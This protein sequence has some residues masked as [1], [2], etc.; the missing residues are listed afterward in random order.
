MAVATA[1][2]GLHV[3]AGNAGA[4]W[5]LQVLAG[6]AAEQPRR[7][8]QPPLDSRSLYRML[9]EG[10]LASAASVAED[11]FEELLTEEIA[12]Y[13][14]S[15][16]VGAGI[17][18]DSPYTLRLLLRAF[19]LRDGLPAPVASELKQLSGAAL[20]VSD[21]AL[22]RAGLGRNS[23]PEG[24]PGRL[25]VPPAREL[26][27]LQR[28]MAFQVDDLAPLLPRSQ[29]GVLDPLTIGVASCRFSDSQLRGGA[30]DR[31][32][33]LRGGDWM[34]LAR[35]FS[36]CTAVRHRVVHQVVA[37]LGPDAATVLFGAE[38]DADVAEAF[39][40]MK[41]P[42][43]IV[44]RRDE[45]EPFSLLRARCDIDKVIAAVVLADDF[46]RLDDRSPYTNFD[47]EPH[48]EAIRAQLEAVAETAAEDGDEVLGLIVAQAAGRS[49]SF[50]P[51]RPRSRNLTITALTAADLDV[52]GFIETGEP[53]ALWKFARAS[54]ALA[55][56]TQISMFSPLDGYGAYRDNERSFAPFRGATLLAVQPGSGAN[57]RWEARSARDRHGV[58][59]SGGTVRE[60][61][62]ESPEEARH[63][64]LY[65]SPSMIREG[66]L[67]RF[68][69][70]A[71]VG[72]WVV[73]APG[74]FDLPLYVLDTVAYWLKELREP[75]G[76]L[77]VELARRLRYVQFDVQLGE[78][79]YWLGSRPEPRSSDTG[80]ADVIGEGRVQL[81][82]GP[83]IRR[84]VPASDNAAD[85]LVLGLLIDGIA[86]IANESGIDAVAL[87]E[88]QRAE[89]IDA[90]APPGVKKHLLFLP[91][92]D[93]PMLEPADERGRP[94]QEA[95]LTA[96]RF[97]V[98]ES[99]SATFGYRNEQ[100]PHERRNDVLHHVVEFLFGEV[101]RVVS[102]ATPDGMLELLM[103]ANERLI[104]DS[105]HRRMILAAREATYP[106][107]VG[108]L[109]DDIARANQAAV[110]CRFL[111]EYTAAQ[112]PSGQG[113]WSTSRYDEALAAT[114]LL[115]DWGNL[116]DAIHGGLSTMDLLVSEHGQLRL[117]EYDRY[118]AGRST[119]FDVYVERERDQSRQRF[120]SQRHPDTGET[121]TMATLRPLDPFVKAEAGVTLNELGELLVAANLV[122]RDLETQI[123]KLTR[124]DAIAALGRVLQWD[125]D[126]AE[127]GSRISAGIAYLSMG[128]RA[129]FLAPPGG[130]APDTYPWLFARR[131]SYNR[132]PFIVRARDSG[133][134]V[135]WGRRH[136]VQAMQIL[137][138][139]MTSGRYQALA[140]TTALRRQLGRIADEK[141]AAFEREVAKVIRDDGRLPVA[142][143]VRRLGGDRLERAPGQSL[144]DIDVLVGDPSTRV[145]WALE[146]KDLSGAA[147]AAEIAREMSEHFRAVG[148]TSMTKHAE[149]VSWLEVR[150]PAALELLRLDGAPEV[151]SVRG[152]VVTSR[153]VHAPYIEDV[154]FP[155]VALSEL[156]AQFG[157]AV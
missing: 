101:R 90:A 30:L 99:L 49:V 25:V 115:L 93:R 106:A 82:L 7:P 10:G 88:R 86:V 139:Q 77:L 56:S 144:G 64:D 69:N 141:G 18:V 87:I 143:R 17:A 55:E 116:S 126:S 40:Q 80:R 72:I 81:T 83:E 153:P 11:P 5:R 22:R 140:E 76:E 128:P 123:V 51:P 111:V 122:A 19:L 146:C 21:V 32:P 62:R 94:V 117:V 28:A 149:R 112:P 2:A 145:I 42:T 4:I 24:A 132:R 36:V 148:T 79:E 1:V 120:A 151:W 118:E 67:A 44:R 73:A 85:R 98:G 78:R 3:V 46:S 130:K 31:W 150:L 129:D 12:F 20:S 27:S 138:G 9:T 70:G 109:R 147:M 107:A 74:D 133:E 29:V 119:Y 63:G 39:L 45:T 48:V 71:P 96:A 58:E 57:Y 26:A 53:L 8:S 91:T 134:E 47:A 16:L 104:A 6:L 52:I 131:W 50:V 114:S 65:Y 121:S 15:Y 135:L 66:I 137:V 125:C 68:I 155:I 110:C 23:F 75:L 113:R 103:T 34:V 13:G 43:Q 59:D 108:E 127:Q 95:D 100:I 37:T 89:I 14:G 156:M 92:D 142:V 97:A 41:L 61:E 154:T 33:I 105:E 60:V 54:A 102:E 84:L 136:V 152:L 38:V 157:N 124:A 35:P